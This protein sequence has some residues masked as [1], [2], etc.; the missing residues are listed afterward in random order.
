MLPRRLVVMRHAKAETYAATDEERALTP[1]GV[2]DAVAAGRYLAEQGLTPDY[3]VVSPARRTMQSWAAASGEGGLDS[4]STT[5]V[6]DR[7]VY[8]GSTE[9]VLE[10]LQAAP[11]AARTVMLVGHN[12]AAAYLVT[13]LDDGSGD[14]DA[15]ARIVAGFPPGAVAVLDVA[16]PWA[17]LGPET[18]RV[19]GFHA[20]SG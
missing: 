7:A 5:V 8:S 6:T 12:P 14:P 16:V 4:S 13:L 9:M 17:E 2:R 10:A 1:R 19:V 18:A 11:E 15:T 20:R 3:A